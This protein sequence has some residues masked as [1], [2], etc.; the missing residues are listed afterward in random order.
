MDNRFQFTIPNEKKNLYNRFALLLF[1]LN[2]AA[3]LLRLFYFN[4]SGSKKGSEIFIYLI[5]LLL[6]IYLS[7]IVYNDSI[8]KYF[9]TFLIA[10][11]S[12]SLF[13]VITGPW[14]I[15]PVT[16]LL[17]LFF[18]MAQRELNI[19]VSASHISY[20]SFPPKKIQW[21]ELNNLVL[22]DGLLT[23]D[24]KNDKLIQQYPEPKMSMPDEREFNEFCRERLGIGY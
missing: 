7:F 19:I 20:P 11:L 12:L 9:K 16:L 13:W 23:I 8:K 15:A 14:W 3:I 10:S 1:I 24:F 4:Q 17:T 18:L 2:A 6:I 21:E 22:K 5:P